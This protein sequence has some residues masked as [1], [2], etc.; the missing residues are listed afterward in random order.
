[1]DNI[2]LNNVENVNLNDIITCILNDTSVLVTGGAGT[3]K[4]HLAKTLY[5][6]LKDNDMNVAIT[7]TTG[8]AAFLINGVTLHSF[9]GFRPNDENEDTAK[10]VKRIKYDRTTWK[11]WIKT[12][13]LIIDE[14]S[15]LHSKMFEKLNEIGKILRRSDEPFGGLL[16]VAFADFYQ[17]PPV[18][19]ENGKNNYIFLSPQFKEVFKDIIVLK[20]VYRQTDQNDIQMLNQIREGICTPEIEA[21]LKSRTEIVP[22]ENNPPTRLYSKIKKVNE[23]NEKMLNELPERMHTFKAIDTI[24][25]NLNDTKF[26]NQDEKNMQYTKSYEK[27]KKCLNDLPLIDT[28]NLKRQAKVVLIY[29]LN[30]E[31][32]LI[33]GSIGTIVDYTNNGN[34][35]VNFDGIGEINIPQINYELEYK[36]LGIAIRSQI[37]LILA[38]ALSIHKSQG[39]TLSNVITSLSRNEIF[40]YGQAY[41]AISRVRSLDTLYIEHFDKSVIKADPLVKEFYDS[42]NNK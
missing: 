16:L 41:V 7:A 13:V 25:V 18:D 17:L 26:N 39:K 4:S 28:L 19:K 3:G 1:M 8:S 21:K 27:L 10:I 34:P 20:E 22:S 11:S 5:E 40:T 36:D 31:I 6:T 30:V 38:F 2:N 9:T 37:P 32:G 29:N 42:L 14:V 35:I 33:N 15:M 24:K 12:D 23:Y